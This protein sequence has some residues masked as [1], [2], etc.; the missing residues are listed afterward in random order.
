MHNHDLQRLDVGE[1]LNDTIIEFGLK[2]W[3]HYDSSKLYLLGPFRLWHQEVAESN[4]Q[5]AEQI[6]VYSPF[7]YKKLDQK[8]KK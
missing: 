5:L 6:H 4:P 7:F 3:I 2:Y 8:K 1:F